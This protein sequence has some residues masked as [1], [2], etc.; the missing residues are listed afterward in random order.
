MVEFKLYDSLS[1]E[2][3]KLSDPINGWSQV[4]TSICN[5]EKEHSEIAAALIYHH[6]LLDKDRQK[7]L[8]YSA[9]ILDGGIGMCLKWNELPLTLKKILQA[10]LNHISQI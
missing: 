4:T 10:Y 6:W 5:L 7:S 3:S 8:P 9:K 2:A 1:I